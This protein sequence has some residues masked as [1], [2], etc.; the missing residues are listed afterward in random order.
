VIRTFTQLPRLA[1]VA[2]LVATLLACNERGLD[3]DI[4]TY[5]PPAEDAGADAAPDA[6]AF[7]AGPR[8][9]GADGTTCQPPR[10]FG[11]CIEQEC[12]R[13]ACVTGFIDC[14]SDPINGCETRVDA[15]DS[16]G[17]CGVTCD[18][19]AACQFG[20][21]G[22]TCS[23]EVVCRLPEFDVDLDLD[24]GCEWRSTWDTGFGA[25]AQP[26]ELGLITSTP[27]GIW[28]TATTE[29]GER[30]LASLPDWAT[31][32]LSEG[33]S[34]EGRARSLE[35]D[36]EAGEL[37]ATWPDRVVRFDPGA[38]AAMPIEDVLPCTQ[39]RQI[40]DVE[41][42]PARTLVAFESGVTTW[43]NRSFCDGC[44]IAGQIF[45]REDYLRAFWVGSGPG[46]F[47]P[48]EVAGCV[49]CSFDPADDT[50]LAPSACA[51]DAC[52]PSG[53]PSNCATCDTRNCPDFDIVRVLSN[54]SDN[55]VYIVTARG[56]VV[57][58]LR[59]TWQPEW[60][61]E[62][63]WEPGVAS[64]ARFVAA[65]ISP[66][67]SADVVSLLDNAGR[68]MTLEFPRAEGEPPRPFPQVG[69]ALA[70][71]ITQVDDVRLLDL[72]A[73][74]LAFVG[75]QARSAA[76]REIGVEDGPQLGGLEVVAQTATEDGFLVVYRAPGVFFRRTFTR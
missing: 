44:T 2:T 76:I 72:E 31:I 34:E 6:S 26:L 39:P 52:R 35:W 3:R 75:A 56:V 41:P 65:D 71:G 4:L 69:V 58:Q 70:R 68:V 73:N 12:Q 32:S 7:P 15:T 37:L 46:A 59:G 43:E 18:D 8:C 53:L 61:L 22:F 48:S 33:Q 50:D 63:M 25:P 47:D 28:A 9:D 54:G 67:D 66:G 24:N 11:V 74:Q 42:H 20:E 57:M 27:T 16:C 30:R 5:R 38:D 45:E 29:T 40:R 49:P 62:R 64:G 23:S 51:P 60:R 13:I 14:D 21:L 36:I 17:A 1:V 19:G 10:A 55:R